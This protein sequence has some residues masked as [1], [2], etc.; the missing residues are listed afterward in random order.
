M[1]SPA[2]SSD[3]LVDVRH[4]KMYFPVM[5][6]LFFQRKVAEVKAVDDVSFFIKRGETLGLVGKAGRARPPSVNGILQLNRATAGEVLLDGTDL[7]GLSGHALRAVRRRM[8]VIFQDP[9]SSLDPRMKVG[10]SSANRC[11]STS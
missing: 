10:T 11:G 9:Y 5:S 8:Q 6:G 2:A 7:T 1:G 4:V 3:V